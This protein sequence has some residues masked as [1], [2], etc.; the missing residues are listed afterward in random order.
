MRYFRIFMDAAT[1]KV[2]VDSAVFFVNR[3]FRIF[4]DA[5]T[6]KAGNGEC[7]LHSG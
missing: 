3:D 2:E 4:M 5:A 6:L 7:D 1:L